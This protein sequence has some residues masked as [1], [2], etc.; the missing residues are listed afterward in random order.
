[1]RCWILTPFVDIV[2]DGGV[3]PNDIK[4][5]ILSHWHYDHSGNLARLAKSTD[6]IVGPGFKKT[7]EPGYPY[8][9]SLRGESVGHAVPPRRVR[10]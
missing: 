9:S 2:K 4:A 5:L 7:H 10:C 6:V 8:V 1:M 3:N